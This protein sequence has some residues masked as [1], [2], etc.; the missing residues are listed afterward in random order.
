MKL[1]RSIFWGPEKKSLGLVTDIKVDHDKQLITL[2]G[3]DGARIADFS[4][5]T[6]SKIKYDN[7]C[8]TIMILK[9]QAGENNYYCRGS[10]AIPPRSMDARGKTL[11]KFGKDEFGSGTYDSTCGD[12]NGDGKNEIVISG[13]I[14][15][16][17]SG[18]NSGNNQRIAIPGQ[19]R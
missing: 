11:W 1:K 6:K 16:D 3:E 13:T 5:V 14:L 2:A 10:W 18:K 8:D 17:S 15:F 7:K 12:I 9:S 4:G 19:L